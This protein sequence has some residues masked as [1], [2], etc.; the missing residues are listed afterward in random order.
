M[1]KG[2]RLSQVYLAGRWRE[3]SV[4]RAATRQRALVCWNK[5]FVVWG[6]EPKGVR[7]SG[8]VFLESAGLLAASVHIRQGTVAFT[9]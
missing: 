6:S 2:G 4:E 8:K 5:G 9:R 1:T 3:V 7:A